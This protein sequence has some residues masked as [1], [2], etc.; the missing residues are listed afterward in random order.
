MKVTIKPFARIAPSDAAVF[1]HIGELF[2]ANGIEVT[3]ESTAV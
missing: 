1:G 2:G 3:V